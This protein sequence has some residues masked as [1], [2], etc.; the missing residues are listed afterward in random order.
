MIATWIAYMFSDQEARVSAP[1]CLNALQTST[2][3]NITCLLMNI[4]RAVMW[5]LTGFFFYWVNPLQMFISVSLEAYSDIH[6][7]NTAVTGKMYFTGPTLRISVWYFKKFSKT[8]M[9]LWRPHSCF[10]ESKAACLFDGY[11]SEMSEEEFWLTV[12]RTEEPFLPFDVVYIV[13]RRGA[14]RG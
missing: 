5:C 11:L 13:S 4:F 1:E 9:M 6:T 8:F 3:A 12:K 7:I 14:G 10:T 2:K